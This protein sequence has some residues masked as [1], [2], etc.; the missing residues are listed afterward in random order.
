MYRYHIIQQGKLLKWKYYIK[1]RNQNHKYHIFR[2]YVINTL[3]I[4]IIII[5][6]Q[7]K[8]YKYSVPTPF[9]IYN[10]DYP[11]LKPTYATD[12]SIPIKITFEMVG[13]ET[14][15]SDYDITI[16]S[17]PPDDRIS[18]ISQYF[19]FYIDS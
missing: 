2:K 13:S 19:N 10:K 11:I 18:L 4:Y 17:N 16:Y 14:P 12:K 5:V 9:E 6:F 15:T 1:N 3:I 8:K 7:C